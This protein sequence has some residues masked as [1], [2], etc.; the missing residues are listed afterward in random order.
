[1]PLQGTYAPSPTAWVRDHVE[2]YE[3]SNGESGGADPEGRR[4]VIL[5]TRGA[6]S[7][8][9]RKNPVMR[10]EHDGDYAAVASLAGAPRNPEWFHNLVANPHLM[11]QDGSMRDDFVARRLEG[12]ERDV[13]W[14]RAVVAYPTYA[15]YQLST[16][17]E[18]PLM[19]LHRAVVADAAR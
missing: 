19:L 18:I 17:R 16:E 7:G 10:V 11:L 3:R 4:I 14:Q 8:L 1:M 12:R 13:W 6:Q 15:D 5:T 2:R 9:L